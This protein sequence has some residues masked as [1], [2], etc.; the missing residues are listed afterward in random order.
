MV[1]KDG[2]PDRSHKS[3]TSLWADSITKIESHFEDNSTVLY[4]DFAKDVKEITEL[5]WQRNIKAGKYTGQIS[6]NEQKQADKS[7]QQ[8][9]LSV[10]VATESYELG[11]D[12]PHINQVIRIG[13]RRI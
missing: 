7:F 8:G 2:L 9:E 12:N 1:D 6:V 4:L 13:C 10:L 3:S 11:V 5:L